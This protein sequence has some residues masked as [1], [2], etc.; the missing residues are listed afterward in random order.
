MVDTS[1]GE[2]TVKIVI[3]SREQSPYGFQDV[4]YKDTTVESGTLTTG[5]YSLVGFTDAVG[6][7]RKSLDDMAGTLTTGRERFERELERSRGMDFFA[8]VIEADLSHV[9]RHCYRSKMA[10][11]AFIQSL[12]SYQV[13]FGCHVVW[14]GCRERGEYATHS[15]LQKYL[16]CQ[17]KKQAALEA[18]LGLKS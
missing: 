12:F 2:S 13:R 1:P 7:E 18:Q 17:E 5:D 15:L 11:T 16:A 6:I 4:K 3:D 14:A 8:I 9:A 10:P